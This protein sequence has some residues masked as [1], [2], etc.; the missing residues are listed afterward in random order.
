MPSEA[1]KAVSAG[2][3]S[4][5]IPYFLHYVTSK[6][7]IIGLPRALA[8]E[9]GDWKIHVNTIA[10]GSIRTEIDRDSSPPDQAQAMIGRRCLKRTGIPQDLTGLLF[11]SDFSP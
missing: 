6:A 8:Q 2:T 4:A 10:L 1:L 11:L 3:V 5:G 7:A 9:V